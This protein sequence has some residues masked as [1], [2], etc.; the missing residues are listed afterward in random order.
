[1]YNLIDLY[2]QNILHISEIKKYVWLIFNEILLKYLYWLQ[3]YR[4]YISSVFFLPSKLFLKK[5]KKRKG[6]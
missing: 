6:L 2:V 4:K 3:L 5:K 1:M